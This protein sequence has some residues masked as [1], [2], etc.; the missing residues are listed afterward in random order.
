MSSANFYLDKDDRAPEVSLFNHDWTD[1]IGLNADTKKVPLG[2]QNW[3]DLTAVDWDSVE[4]TPSGRYAELEWTMHPDWY[5]HDTHW[6]GFGPTRVDSIPSVGSPWYLDMDTPVA[7][8]A[9]EGGFSFAEHQRS[10]AANDLT[11][12]DSCLGEIIATKR[13]VDN[14]PVPP[15]YDRERLSATFH[16]ITTLQKEGAAA[17]R[18]AWDRLAFL[19]WWTSACTDWADGV[20]EVIAERLGRI[21][22]RGR[23]PRGFLF[24]LLT[25]WHEMNIPFL[26]ARSIPFYYMF[27]LEARLNERFCRLNPKILASYAGP[28]GDE[29]V[30]H[31]IDYESDTEA[32]EAAT[33]RYD[34]F[35]QLLR[36]NVANDHMSYESDSS[37]FII[38]FEGWGRRPITSDREHRCF[39]AC[40]HF[41]VV[42]GV[43]DSPQVIFWRFR[44][45]L[46]L[47]QQREHLLWDPQTNDPTVVRELFK[48][49]FA[50]TPSRRFHPEL[51]TLH[52]PHTKSRGPSSTKHPRTTLSP[53]PLASRLSMAWETSS[54]DNEAPISGV[55]SLLARM[56]HQGASFKKLP[57]RQVSRLD[58]SESNSSGTSRSRSSQSRQRSQSPQPRRDRHPTSPAESFKSALSEAVARFTWKEKPERLALLADSDRQRAFVF[59]R[60]FLCIP[61]WKSQVRMRYYASCRPEVSSIQQVVDI[62]VV[63]RLEFALAVR[64]S[65]VNLFVPEV[66]SGL[67]RMGIKAL[68]QPGFTEPSFSYTKG[69]PA[70]FANTYLA[71]I[72]DILR[73]P[74]ARA[75]VGMGGPYSWIAERF[76]GPAIVKAFLSGPSIQ[77]TRHL[78]GRSDSH[79]ENPIG[80]QWDQVSAQEGSFLFGFV[81]SQ[82]SSTPE[83]YLFP[84]PHYLRELCDHWTGDWN[85]VMDKIFTRIA[86]DIERGKAEPH[87]RSWWSSHLRNYNRLPKPV[88][89]KFNDA[90]VEEARR[91][92]WRGGLPRTWDRMLIKSITVPEHRLL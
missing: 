47:A 13:F 75:F 46:P 39:S 32:A 55:P 30:M 42:G 18:A 40:F 91:I 49:V 72:N 79:E 74:H 16:S 68:Y 31:D 37:F 17:K 51:G 8:C 89:P 38:D 29:V 43:D 82:D 78:L 61:D 64:V 83:R 15:P 81:P 3:K 86:D 20:N 1:W 27:P 2:A 60:A 26:L 88:N 84:P 57:V 21:V 9:V 12:L 58:S 65:D 71:K 92:L 80:L 69:T 67:D 25:D 85:E 5:R 6:R 50:P 59:Q 11:F 62:A 66:V 7:Y 28:D 70:I 53:L 63:H 73:R 76:G 35:F 87:E 52:P 33:H 90:D 19:T 41:T 45:K 23:D 14:S 36:P 77:V 54:T 44:P 22:S 10:N 48:G 34:D 4:V 56:S 24:D